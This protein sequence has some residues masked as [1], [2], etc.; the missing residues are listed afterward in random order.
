MS[1]PRRATV[2]VFLSASGG[3]GRTSTVANLAWVLAAAD[4][5]VLVLDRGSEG[6]RVPEY[7]EPFYLRDVVLAEEFGG[8]APAARDRSANQRGTAKRYA[9]PGG[10]GHI[11]VIAD[12]PARGI[13]EAGGAALG[14]ARTDT[15]DYVLI[16]A[17][18]GDDSA[19]LAALAEVADVGVVCFVPRSK[20]IRNAVALALAF[21]GHKPAGLPI[22]PVATMFNPRDDPQA[23][24]SL[25]AIRTA[26]SPLA[27]SGP[28]TTVQIP[29]R[30]YEAFDPLLAVLAED[31]AGD[32][33][34]REQ[35]ERLAA[36]VTDG[37]VIRMPAMPRAVGSRYRRAF[38]LEDIGD[39]DRIVVAYA[40]RDRPWAEWAC[41][42]LE[43]A[44]AQASLLRHHREWM[45]DESPCELVVISSAEWDRGKAETELAALLDQRSV[46]VVRL[47]IEAGEH[48][49]V[50]VDRH[51]DIARLQ[52]PEARARL[53]THFG[54]IEPPDA[55]G[56]VTAR[57]PTAEPSV[58]SLP[59]RHTRFVGREDDIEA[60]RDRLSAHGGVATVG[61]VPGIGKSELALEY[62][63]RFA[64]DYDLVWWL[65]AH[66]RQAVLISVSQLGDHMRDPDLNDPVP[67]EYGT[68]S[69]LDE[70][71]GGRRYPRW[72][73][74]YDNADT[75][76]VLD[77]LVPSR[78]GGHVVVTSSTA[79][80]PDLE[81]DELPSGDSIRLLV[82]RVRGLSDRDADRVARAVDHVPLALELSVSWLAEAVN[83]ERR[84]GTDVVDA[85]TWSV[86]DFLDRLASEHPDREVVA[87]LVAV[88]TDSLRQDPAGRVAV[89]LAEMC[90]FLSTQGVGLRFVRS[91]AMTNALADVGGIDARSLRLDS[92]EIDRTLWLGARFGL[93][94]V[95][96]GERSNLRLHRVVQ[97]ALL[98]AMSDDQRA[99]R[100]AQVL[101]ALA[102][103]APTEAEEAE[104]SDDGRRT[105]AWRFRELQKH[106]FTSGALGSDDDAVRR[107]LV[108]Q[109][110]FLYTDGGSGVSLASTA[111][112]HALLERWT[113]Q[114]GPDDPLRSRLATQLANVERR[115]GKAEVALELD[116]GALQQQRRTLEL[117]NPQTLI[118]ARGLGGDLRGLGE[119]GEALDEDYDTWQGLREAFGDDHPHTRSAA[120]NLAE[121]KFL[122]GDPAGALEL[123]IDNFERRR[124]LFGPG[125]P[126]TWWS[127]TRIGV[128]L[129][130]LGHYK[131]AVDALRGARD[132]LRGLDNEISPVELVAGWHLAITQRLMGDA[133]SAKN[134]NVQILRRLRSAQGIHHPETL[135]CELSLAMDHR[136]LGDAMTAVDHSTSVVDGLRKYVGLAE[137]HPF[138]ALARLCLGLSMSAAD[139]AE[140]GAREVE[141]ALEVIEGRLGEVHPWALAAAVARAQVTAALGD[142]AAARSLVDEAHR[143][144]RVFL[145]DRHPATRIAGHNLS[146]ARDSGAELDKGWRTID[147]DI[148]Q[149]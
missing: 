6:P 47:R 1:S 118:T 86:R 37:G 132:E 16:D 141:A 20:A 55:A 111:P 2:V 14:A 69:P 97:R 48:G 106:V 130:E 76:G 137:D 74:I 27:S 140:K 114:F 89:L 93:F 134:A 62:A 39:R 7:L 135:A 58:R 148:P 108:N 124:R 33:G 127:Q 19:E 136:Q 60:L 72:L 87:R 75:E 71:T 104:E 96:W 23:R 149:T 95:D 83:R 98:D 125:D 38:G 85:V 64:S 8:G 73:L 28:A 90:A 13:S 9:L 80:D 109:L 102:A 61:G 17:P 142:R 25:D 121:S 5:R 3:T 45:T 63:H 31:P 147:V 67:T 105:R 51:I 15:H 112:G 101:G 66:D 59:P 43:R 65:P 117:A 40:P 35:Y 88:L 11:D 44:G 91:S 128:Y 122:S 54:L 119:F 56:D 24:R 29:Y 92:W 129:R 36:A 138:V 52:E 18:T 81:L 139:Q 100:R 123:E 79:A 53:L 110:R 145:G 143:R 12:V 4:R 131:E 116:Q 32:Q 94:R 30:P 41:G 70:L 78:E 21:R 126:K 46:D 82:T 113:R 84:T 77:D 22:V 99:K 120:N 68:T 57:F 42:V 146:V 10:A 103:F 107:W 144:C 26:F 133:K 49:P 115:L 50:S 34:L